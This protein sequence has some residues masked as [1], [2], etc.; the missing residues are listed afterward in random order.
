ML[1]VVVCAT[2]GGSASTSSGV[3]AN[4]GANG[5]T[6]ASSGVS[7]SGGAN[8]SASASSCVSASGSMCQWLSAPG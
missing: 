6:S 5:S 8:G 4:G 2:G 7:A 3:S 1:P